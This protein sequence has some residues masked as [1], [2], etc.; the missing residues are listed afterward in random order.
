MEME[1]DLQIMSAGSENILRHYHNHRHQQ[2][3]Q[4]G[5]DHILGY[6]R[7]F[8]LLK[9]HEHDRAE[10]EVSLSHLILFVG[11]GLFCL[12]PHILTDW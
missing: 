7:G 2:C 10:A 11:R 4:S 6:K 12:G 8:W 1:I 9:Y 5:L 3:L